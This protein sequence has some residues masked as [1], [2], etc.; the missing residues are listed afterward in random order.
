[1]QPIFQG[2]GVE[3]MGVRLRWEDQNEFMGHNLHGMYFA[4]SNSCFYPISHKDR[5]V[6]MFVKVRK[7]GAGRKTQPRMQRE[8][9]P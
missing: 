3:K 9:N 2:P 8:Q 4:L 1:M 5:A 6:V 7:A